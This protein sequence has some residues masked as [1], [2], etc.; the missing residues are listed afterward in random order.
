MVNKSVRTVIGGDPI[1]L[2]NLSVYVTT[3]W[4]M[5]KSLLYVTCKLTVPPLFS[6]L[7]SRFT[8]RFGDRDG[9]GSSARLQ[10]PM[11]ICRFPDDKLLVADCYNNK[12]RLVTPE[13]NECRLFCGT[14]T[15]GYRDGS[16]EVGANCIQTQEQFNFCSVPLLNRFSALPSFLTCLTASLRDFPLQRA[17]PTT[18]SYRLLS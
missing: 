16:R 14:G 17:S 7:F 5:H 8:C 1:F 3:C 9:Y 11:G 12:I 4:P 2:G 6:P 13:D 18:V 15:P 10:R